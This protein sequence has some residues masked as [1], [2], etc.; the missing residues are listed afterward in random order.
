MLLK[1]LVIGKLKDKNFQS[2]IVE[3]SKWLTQ[4]NKIEILELPDSTK[5]KENELLLKH[6]EKENHAYIVALSEDGKE[7]TSR[8]LASKLGAI[9]QKIVF[10]IGGPYGLTSEV[11]EKADFL[12][13]LSKLTFTHEFARLILLEQLFRASNI[14]MGG[15][16]HND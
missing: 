11:K 3:Y 14:Q 5:E 9:Q 10:I 7:L 6:I 15:S 2:R 13:S 4:N 1:V 12:W 16:Y 8:E